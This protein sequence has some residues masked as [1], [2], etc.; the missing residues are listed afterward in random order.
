MM[1]LLMAVNCIRLA[2]AGQQE[3]SLLQLYWQHFINDTQDDDYSIPSLIWPPPGCLDYIEI[4]EATSI[5]HFHV[6]TGGI[7][8]P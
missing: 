3:I 8:C 1:K 5:P 6:T 2:C 7:S 4:Q